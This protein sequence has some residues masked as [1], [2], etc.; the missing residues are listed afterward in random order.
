LISS[1]AARRVATEIG[2]HRPQLL[3]GAEQVIDLFVARTIDR[4]RAIEHV[5]VGQRAHGKAMLVMPD[6][7]RAL[8]CIEGELQIALLQN[9][10]IMIAEERRDELAVGAEPLPID[11]ERVGVR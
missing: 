7:E 5:R 3:G 1:Q 9:G 10:A 11:V 8:G 2:V 6:T 4:G